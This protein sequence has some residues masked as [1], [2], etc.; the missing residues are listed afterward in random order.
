VGAGRYDEARDL[1]RDQVLDQ[2]RLQGGVTLGL[3]HQQPV[4]APQGRP[5]AAADELAA[6]VA[7]GDSVGD[8]AD[9][10]TVLGPQAAGREVG[11]VVQ[12]AGGAQ[13]AL[14]GLF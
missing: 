5:H 12:L 3:A 2:R 8:Q 13:H 1:A 6:V 10:A 11:A 4:P 7:G 9:R 14:A